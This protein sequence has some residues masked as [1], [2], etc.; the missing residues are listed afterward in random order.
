MGQFVGFVTLEGTLTFP[1]AANPNGAAT[2]ADAAPSYRVMSP[3]MSSTLLASQTAT[4][5]GTITGV[6]KVSRAINAADGFASG[7]SY[8][9]IANYAISSTARTREFTFGVV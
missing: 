1:F 6:Y 3:T 8:N 5:I 2:A 9:V 7:Q 4:T